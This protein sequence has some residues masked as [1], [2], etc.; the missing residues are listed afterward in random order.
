MPRTY[1]GNSIELRGCALRLDTLARNPDECERVT[2]VLDR[3]PRGPGL[4]IAGT[5]LRHLRVAAD[6]KLMS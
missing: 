5:D 1:R 6:P 4:T 3:G 2:A